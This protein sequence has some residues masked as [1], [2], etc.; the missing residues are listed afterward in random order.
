MKLH[1]VLFL[2]DF[3]YIIFI[4]KEI[5]IKIEVE[6]FCWLENYSTVRERNLAQE[7]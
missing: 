5:T 6:T 1:F 2:L 3:Y 4:G 7:R